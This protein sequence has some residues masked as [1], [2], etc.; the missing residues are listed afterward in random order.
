MAMIRARVAV[1]EPQATAMNCE[2]ARHGLSALVGG[3][4]GLTDWALL[5]VHLKHCAECRQAEA[6][7]RQLATQPVTQSRAVMVALRKAM[8][9]AG[10]GVICS[11]ALVVRRRALLTAAARELPPSVSVPIFT[12]WSVLLIQKWMLICTIASSARRRWRSCRDSP[13]NGGRHP[14]RERPAVTP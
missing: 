11:T 7:L 1:E 4:I 3:S 2:D 10:I 6:R 5:E 12:A 14:N 8:E 9:L 13:T